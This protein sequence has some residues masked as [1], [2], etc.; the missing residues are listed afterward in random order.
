MQQM[1][2]HYR[3][4]CSDKIKTLKPRH[5]DLGH[6]ALIIKVEQL[7]VKNVEACRGHFRRYV[8]DLI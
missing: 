3:Y 4:A 8:V 2:G 7:S 6:T 5:V 1:L